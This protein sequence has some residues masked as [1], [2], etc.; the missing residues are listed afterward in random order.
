MSSVEV[1]NYPDTKLSYDVIY[2]KRS[3]LFYVLC[4]LPTQNLVFI[5]YYTLQAFLYFR[6]CV[7]VFYIF[8]VHRAFSSSFVIT[9]VLF[10]IIF[11]LFIGQ[12][13]DIISSNKLH[14]SYD[15]F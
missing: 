2:S 4:F 6:L 7:S 3:H 8:Q 1:G 10:A 14:I 11:R 5:A 15:L 9:V 13:I 12:R